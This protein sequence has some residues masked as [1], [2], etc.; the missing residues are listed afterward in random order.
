MLLLSN[1]YC[2]IGLCC[3]V[4]SD[5]QNGFLLDEA[6]AKRCISGVPLMHSQLL[7]GIQDPGR[8]SPQE[9]L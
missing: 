7:V 5:V 8:V 9:A 1:N 3:T 6:T 4:V 2:Y